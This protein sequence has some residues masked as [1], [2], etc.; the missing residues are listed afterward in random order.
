M[1]EVD[2]L[3]LEHYGKK[4]M[5]WGQRSSAADR[6]SNK[7]KNKASRTKDMAK[8]KQDVEKARATV[9][10]GEAKRKLKT[11]KEAHASNKAKL[12]SREARKILMQERIKY[13]ET[14]TTSQQAKDGKEVAKVILGGV[15]GA[16]AAVAISRAITKGSRF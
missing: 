14:V 4:G 8:F 2:E 11:A 3:L 5:H 9:K 16:I 7:A 12:G 10:S 13:N 6:A 1:N 15:A